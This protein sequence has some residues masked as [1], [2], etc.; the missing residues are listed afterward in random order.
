VPALR[1]PSSLKLYMMKREGQG[2]GGIFITG[3]ITVAGAIHTASQL[4]C[5]VSSRVM[6]IR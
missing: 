3:E 2:D 6:E 1:R 4:G 5:L